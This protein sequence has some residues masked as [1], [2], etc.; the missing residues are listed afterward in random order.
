MKSLATTLAIAITAAICAT[1]VSFGAKNVSSGKK[2]FRQIPIPKREHG[3]SR[4]NPTVIRTERE[5]DDL[6]KRIKKMT[7]WNK[8]KKF[9][10]TIKKA[11]VDFSKEVLVLLPHKEHSG[12]IKVTFKKPK[13]RNRELICRIRRND[14]LVHT[15]DMAYYCFALAVSKAAVDGIELHVKGRKPVKLS[16]SG[17]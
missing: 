6:L 8:P 16:I 7:G 17:K 15:C 1:H 11:K 3:Y 13:L 14:P 9:E 12:S 4:M 10:D 2:V 5:L